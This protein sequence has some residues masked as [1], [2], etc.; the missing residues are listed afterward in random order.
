MTKSLRPEGGKD[1]AAGKLN[2]KQHV[3]RVR[4]SV[5]P[6]PNA[7]GPRKVRILVLC[8]VV[9]KLM[10]A[11]DLCRCNTC[12]YLVGLLLKRKKTDLLDEMSG[13]GNSV[14]GVAGDNLPIS[15][16]FGWRWWTWVPDLSVVGEPG[17]A[18]PIAKT[19]LLKKE[20]E[21]MCENL[22]RLRHVDK[23]RPP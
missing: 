6:C 13:V 14:S 5:F 19:Q 23:P 21:K 11:I 12:F 9:E 16:I 20:N 8:F 4:S 2:S 7:F 18:L 17:H 1:N 15:W 22:C 3:V 10:K